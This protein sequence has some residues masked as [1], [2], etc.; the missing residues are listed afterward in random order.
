MIWYLVVPALVIAG[1]LARRFMG[2]YFG[3]YSRGL[4]VASVGAVTGLA[5]AAVPPHLISGVLYGLLAAL[6]AG[7]VASLG[8][9]DAT[10]LGEYEGEEPDQGSWDFF[11]G[12]SDNKLPFAQR[13]KR[14][15]EVLVISGFFQTFFAG[16]I[17]AIAGGH[18]AAGAILAFSGMLKAPAYMLAYAIPSTITGFRRGRELGEALW[19]ASLGLSAGLTTALVYA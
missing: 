1:A 5:A 8:D 15:I 10:D 17:V 11:A 13:R 14:D 19:G 7:A 6:I 12:Q 16:A 2:G 3:K 18:L 4:E 9:G